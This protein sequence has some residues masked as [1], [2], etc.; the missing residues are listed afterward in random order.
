MSPELF[1]SR[2]STRKVSRNPGIKACSVPAFLILLPMILLRFSFAQGPESCV[3]AN[4]ESFNETATSKS[5]AKTTTRLGTKY[6]VDQIGRRGIGRGFNLFSFERERKLGDK[7]AAELD[8]S[9]IIIDDPLINRCLNRIVQA[10]VSHSEVSYEVTVR[11]VYDDD[12]VNAYSL[13]GGHLYMTSGLFLEVQNEAEMAM[14]MAHE[15][16]HVAARHDT[17]TWTR[18]IL[19]DLPFFPILKVPGPVGYSA[20]QITSALRSLPVMKFNRNTEYEADLLGLEYAY[21]AGYDPQGMLDLYERSVVEDGHGPNFI[22]RL[23]DTHPSMKDRLRRAKAGTSMI[24][25]PRNAYVLDTS[26]FQEAKHQLMDIVLEKQRA[27]AAAATSEVK[28]EAGS[29]SIVG[30]GPPPTP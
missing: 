3:L 9:V 23:F 19:W 28:P 4:C 24:L 6:D 25:P 27:E 7:L 29:E 5:P 18:E 22:V 15:I 26:E 17:R 2:L 13:P 8:H 12:D 11:L 14:V 30:N 10:L 21:S 1:D 16:A 20:Q